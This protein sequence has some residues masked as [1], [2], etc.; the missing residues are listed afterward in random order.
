MNN[1]TNPSPC[2]L[3]NE[4]LVIKVREWVSKLAKTGGSAWTLSVPVNFERDPDILIEELCKRFER[5]AADGGGAEEILMRHAPGWL[6]KLP[7][8]AKQDFI[9]AMNEHAALQ[10]YATSNQQGGVRW[11]KALEPPKD[12]EVYYIRDTVL[13]IKGTALFK[14]GSW[15]DLD[16]E[17]LSNTLIEWLSESPSINKDAVEGDKINKEWR[18]K[19]DWL[20]EYEVLRQV[21][22]QKE[23]IY[24]LTQMVISEYES[25][26]M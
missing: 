11:V 6:N 20:R 9:D 7:P 15:Y 3:N 12:N 26:Y 23:A 14:N 10:P 5:P 16:G 1:N 4:E 13:K 17:V 8:E 21:M 18:D 22:N 24:Q 2:K 25:R 19:E